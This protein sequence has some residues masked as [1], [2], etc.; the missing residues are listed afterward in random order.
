VTRHTPYDA[1]PEF[2]TVDEFR[3]YMHLGR[4][5]TYDLL[6]SG[7]VMHQRFGRTIRIPKA[8]LRKDGETCR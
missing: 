2:L 5:T 8:A 3:M 1:L 4:N 7:A 6:R